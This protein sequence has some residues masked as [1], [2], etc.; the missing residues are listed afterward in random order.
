MSLVG[1]E[2]TLLCYA[3]NAVG[4]TKQPCKWNIVDIGRIS[5]CYVSSS[6]EAMLGG[7]KNIY[8]QSELK[9]EK[10]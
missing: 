2:G 6:V 4:D 9:T 1:G 7:H 10:G 5:T 8:V 3:S